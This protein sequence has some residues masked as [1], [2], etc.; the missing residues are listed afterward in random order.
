MILSEDYELPRPQADR[1][2]TPLFSTAGLV[3]KLVSHNILDF[4]NSAE[5]FEITWAPKI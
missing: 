5:V 4:F 3:V 2:G 1:R